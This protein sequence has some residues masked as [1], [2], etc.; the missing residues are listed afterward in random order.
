MDK[1]YYSMWS[2]DWDTPTGWRKYAHA[3][4]Q[5]GIIINIIIIIAALPPPPPAADAAA[6]AAAI[7]TIL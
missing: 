4:M 3:R 5:A 6:A 2:K 7:I 1:I